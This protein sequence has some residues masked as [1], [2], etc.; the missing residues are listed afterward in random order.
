MFIE[1]KDMSSFNVPRDRDAWST[2]R[3][4]VYQV[5]LTIQ[6]WLYLEPN[7][8]LEI[9][10]GEDIDIVTTA[11]IAGSEEER[12]RLLEQVKHR[13][14]SLTLRTPEAIAAIANFLDHCQTNPRAEIIFQFTTN[15]KVGKE[16]PSPLPKQIPAIE[17]WELL[18][19][20][21]VEEEN[22]SKLITGIREILK[23][24]KKPGDLHE[25]TWQ[26]FSDFIKTAT[27]ETF[28]ELI[29]KFYWNT[30]APD[31]K[32]LKSILQEKLLNRGKA[33]DV[34]QAKEQYHR[35][36]WY[37]FSRLSQSGIKQLT[38]KEL[39]TQLTL[40]SLNDTDSKTLENF[41]NWFDELDNRVTNL[42]QVQEEDQQLLNS[43]KVEVQQLAKQQGIE[44]SISYVVSNPILDIYPLVERYSLRE[45]TVQTLANKLINHTWVAI[46]GSFGSGKTQL[47]VLLVQYLSSQKL[48][49]NCKWLRFRDL[50]IE[51]ACWRF[52]QAIETLVGHRLKANIQTWYSQLIE[53]LGPKTIL[54][55]DDLP[56]MKRGDELEAR[57]IQ[58]ATIC[59][60]KNIRL[61]STS[62]YQLPQNLQSI[63]GNQILYTMEVPS[64]TNS[65]AAEIF[66]AYEAPESFLNSNWVESL[67]KLAQQHPSLL[68]SMA[69]YLQRKNWETDKTFEE[70]IKG[71]HTS[72]INEET[73]NFILE[74]IQ[75]DQTQELLY[76]VNLVLGD[77]SL[78]DIR[79]LANVAPNIER[80]RQRLNQ[81]LGIWIQRDVND[82]FTVSPLIN[83]LGSQD[84]S[85]AVRKECHLALGER[86]VQGEISQYKAVRAI[87][88][89]IEADAFNKAGALFLGAL[90]TLE[91]STPQ[92]DDA[93][94]LQIWSHTP[95]PEQMDLGIRLLI[96]AFQISI[97]VSYQKSISYLLESLDSLIDHITQQEAVM[98]MGVVVRLLAKCPDEVGALRLNR[99]FQTALRFSSIPRLPDGRELSLPPDVP[100]ELLLWRITITIQNSVD[101]KE[102]IATLQQLTS[103]QR[104]RAFATKAKVTETGCLFVAER[105]WRIEA[106]KPAAKQDWETVLTTMRLLK[107]SAWS[108]DIKLLWANAVCS[109]VIILSQYKK[110][111]P[112]AIEVAQSAIAIAGDS[113]DPRL[114]FLL[115]E[116]LGRQFLFAEHYNE[117]T[118][119]L[120]ESVEQPLEAYPLLKLHA[121]LR[122][123][124]AIG[125]QEPYL[126]IQYAEQGLNLARA[127]EEIPEIELVK[128]LGELAIAKWLASDLSAAF[129]SWERAGDYLL[130]Y[131]SHNNEWKEMFVL[132][133]HIT[134]YFNSLA[135]KGTP[136]EKT[137]T[138][139]KY[140]E[141]TRGIFLTRNPE[142]IN[143]YNPARD[144]FLATQLASF[145]EAIGNDERSLA[146]AMKGIDMARKS[147]QLLPVTSLGRQ[148]IPQLILNNKYDEVLDLAVEL[149]TL[150]VALPTLSQSGINISEPGIDIQSVMPSRENP[151]WRE[152]ESYTLILGV[153]PIM[154]H[155]ADIAICNPQE[156]KSKAINLASICHEISE[157]SS[158]QSLWITVAEI[159]DQVHLRQSSYS[160]LINKYQNISSPNEI[161]FILGLMAATLQPNA[162][163]LDFLS[164]HISIIE[165]VQKLTKAQ[166][167]TWRNIILAYFFNYWKTSVERVSFRF[168]NPQLVATLLNKSQ[169][170][171]PDQQGI[172]ILSIIHKYIIDN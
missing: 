131:P 46:N 166:S 109:E 83:A 150:L 61:L 119:L 9:E 171:A 57:L 80:P 118:I 12:N 43:L 104:K 11:L 159:I 146:W 20:G 151:I 107:D 30:K 123:S 77:F 56:Q 160:E 143:H 10:R 76:R 172:Y 169:K 122:L 155:I 7:Q 138:G 152:A 37:V 33:I 28:F 81:L 42:E 13:E 84:L 21:K 2:I 78:E 63:I 126:G 120:K 92:I 73:I 8:I 4:Y 93:G 70:I 91:N 50:K 130:K 129:E 162:T 99:Y 25:N 55:F 44:G 163:L 31:A 156:A 75:D 98:I 149:G 121:F 66:K 139:E 100:F 102:W 89:F 137:E 26:K 49:T 74:N 136:P 69:E 68:A 153:M 165:K 87:L 18:R 88:H 72:D 17:A 112:Q 67:N 14:K 142:R 133:A 157:R 147:Q 64:F 47:G 110:N 82:I 161:L 40:P 111:L 27:D 48:Y 148:I 35:L 128:A 164:V 86:I 15:T 34:L 154:F 52:D 140:T 16:R 95:L 45:K 6:R 60:Q 62:F 134:G 117:A 90:D 38:L 29:Y 1:N 115:K 97:R 32:S 158:S 3:G 127:S 65:E 79:T 71:K 94:L 96:R 144:C 108:M 19:S 124:Q 168:K 58:F 54:V 23:S 125:I 39:D 5:D 113:N 36:F 135:T 132:Y 141:P 114:E 51:Q 41:K 59:H 53:Y 22:R 85:V 167:T 103:E 170:L 24:V 106:D 145:A 101:I 105:L 116:C